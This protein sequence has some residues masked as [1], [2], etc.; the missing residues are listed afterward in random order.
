MKNIHR[1]HYS[2]GDAKVFL[3]R[4]LS[5]PLSIMFNPINFFNLEGPSSVCF[6]CLPPPALLSLTFSF[7]I[8]VLFSFYCFLFMM[9]AIYFILIPLRWPPAHNSLI[10]DPERRTPL[11]LICLLHQNK[12]KNK[13]CKLPKCGRNCIPVGEINCSFDLVALGK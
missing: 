8:S 10:I 5:Y 4:F 9:F 1:P 11:V 2:A 7:L 13:K 12:I 6:S 3:S